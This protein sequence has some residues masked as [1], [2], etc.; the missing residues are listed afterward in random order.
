MAQHTGLAVLFK[1]AGTEG[2]QERL[3]K[4]NR[5]K[6]TAGVEGL[7]GIH[8]EHGRTGTNGGGKGGARVGSIWEIT[9][10]SFPSV[11]P[12]EIVESERPWGYIM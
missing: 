5:D 1:M 12:W 2:W 3:K 11:Y 8:G 6:K 9:G 7:R 10:H 4:G